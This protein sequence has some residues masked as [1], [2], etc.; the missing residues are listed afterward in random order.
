MLAALGFYAGAIDG[1]AGTGTRAAVLAY[2]KS[3]PDLVDDGIAGPATRASLERDILARRRIGEAA[4][5]AAAGGTATAATSILADAGNPFTLA[6]ARR[7]RRSS[8]SPSS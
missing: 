3:H 8:P 4:A 6:L 1:I 2:Q 7:R 5:S